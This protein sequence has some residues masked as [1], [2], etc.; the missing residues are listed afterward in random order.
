ME[1][2]L[3]QLV[4]QMLSINPDRRPTATEVAS[5]LRFI[6]VDE[7]SRPISQLYDQILGQF[8][9]TEALV[10]KI[11]F[12]SWKWIYDM[13][14]S[15]SNLYLE[16]PG[17]N[18]DFQA[19]LDSLADIRTELEMILSVGGIDPSRV[20]LPIHHLNNSLRDLLPRTLQE[21]LQTYLEYKMI[22]SQG[23]DILRDTQRVLEVQSPKSRIG[24]LAA[25]KCMRILALEHG[26]LSESNL[27]IDPACLDYQGSLAHCDLAILKETKPGQTHQCLVEWMRYES[28]IFD[29][30]VGREKFVR[31]EAIAE[32]LHLADKPD[33]FHT[34]QCSGYFHDP[35]EC[36]F[37]LVFDFPYSRLGKGALL[38]PVTLRQ[39]FDSPELRQQLPILGDRFKLA[40]ILALSIAEFHKVGWLHKNISSSNVIFF[41]SSDDAL[42]DCATEPFI[43][44]FNHSR[45]ND[46]AS[47]TSFLS[48]GT[49]NHI[50]YQHPEYLQN[51]SRYCPEF[52]YYSLG[53]V[54][55]EI[56]RW[57]SLGTILNRGRETAQTYR[58][59]LLQKRV[60]HLKQL[61]GTRYFQAVDTCL[62]GGFDAPPQYQETLAGGTAVQLEFVRLVVE[63]LSKCSV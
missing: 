7:R 11:R 45:P 14:S 60:P 8:E 56:G 47:C 48:S 40:H 58:M 9:T 41:L 33:G 28:P 22:E 63:Q 59:N 3:L 16:A 62:R 51:R 37:G 4:R 30:H 50:D 19:T 53:I 5:R 32:L 29:E 31:I 49:L 13:V 20:F 25:I 6:A 27:R 12:E 36:R 54:L 61:M 17:F 57:N 42:V 55:L 52:D 10:E 18:L 35:K 38:R 1:L 26:E 15:K 21:K 39:V 2:Q 46:P 44:G 24:M 23:L 34:L 43:I